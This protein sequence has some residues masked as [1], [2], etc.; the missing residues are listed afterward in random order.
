M[1]EILIWHDNRMSSPINN[2]EWY[3]HR[4]EVIT[5][6][7]DTERVAS[8]QGGGAAQGDGEGGDEAVDLVVVPEADAVNTVESARSS[9]ALAPRRRE[10]EETRVFMCRKWL[11]SRDTQLGTQAR[12]VYSELA[13]HAKLIE[14]YDFAIVMPKTQLD[15]HKNLPFEKLVLFGD[16]IKDGLQISLPKTLERVFSLDHVMFCFKSHVGLYFGVLRGAMFVDRGGAFL[17]ASRG[18]R[19]MVTCYERAAY[20]TVHFVPALVD[21]SFAHKALANLTATCSPGWA[22]YGELKTMLRISSRQHAVEPSA[23]LDDEMLDGNEVSEG[24]GRDA[25]LFAQRHK[26]HGTID[27]RTEQ[28]ARKDSTRTILNTLEIWSNILESEDFDEEESLQRMIPACARLTLVAVAKHGALFLEHLDKLKFVFN[29]ELFPMEN[30]RE[31]ETHADLAIMTSVFAHLDKWRRIEPNTYELADIRISHCFAWNMLYWQCCTNPPEPEAIAFVLEHGGF[32]SHDDHSDSAGTAEFVVTGLEADFALMLHF[33]VLRQMARYDVLALQEEESEAARRKAIEAIENRNLGLQRRWSRKINMC[34]RAAIF[35]ILFLLAVIHM[36][37][38]MLTAALLASGWNYWNDR[39]MFSQFAEDGVLQ[40][41]K[42]ESRRL[43]EKWRQVCSGNFSW[44]KRRCPITQE[45]RRRQEQRHQL[46]GKWTD[47]IFECRRQFM[48][49]MVPQVT[50]IGKSMTRWFS[51]G[52]TQRLASEMRK[53]STACRKRE[54]VL[55][56][57]CRFSPVRAHR[58]SFAYKQFLRGG[59][60]NLVLLALLV[61]CLFDMLGLGWYWDAGSDLS[62][63]LRQM[64]VDDD[65]DDEHNT[66]NEIDKWE[67]WWNFAKGTLAG[68]LTAQQVYAGSDYR[69]DLRF[70]PVLLRQVRTQAGDDGVLP[71]WGPGPSTSMED[72]LPLQAAIYLERHENNTRDG[73]VWSSPPNAHYLS[74]Y[75]RGQRYRKYPA[76]GY[77]VEL[78]KDD[79]VQELARLEDGG[80]FDA[81]TRFVSVEGMVYSKSRDRM[82]YVNLG[83]EVSVAGW[84]R[85]V[86]QIISFKPSEFGVWHYIFMIIFVQTLGNE[87]LCILS[88]GPRRYFTGAGNIINLLMAGCIFSVFICQMVVISQVGKYDRTA[89]N[90]WPAGRG[91]AEAFDINWPLVTMV[92]VQRVCASISILIWFLKFLVHFSTVP[93]CGP[94]VLGIFELLRQPVIL[95]FLFCYI[96]ML[97]GFALC[98]F[99]LSADAVDPSFRQVWNSL[100]SMVRAGL[101]GDFEFTTYESMDTFTG[102]VL[103]V[104]MIIMSQI[105]MTNLFI[106]IISNEYDVARKKGERKW[107][108]TMALY[109][110]QELIDSLPVDSSGNIDMHSSAMLVGHDLRVGH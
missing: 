91:V 80:W 50:Q 98:F 66:F 28:K 87:A 100:S 35:P 27:A 46:I 8:A 71:V 30:Q 84:T 77:M 9:L 33:L 37:L 78:T 56:E 40:P 19:V 53:K 21:D 16:R 81:A 95:F 76:S 62:A 31:M 60:K 12:L 48:M 51:I 58:T 82:A 43:A 75:T 7:K 5:R 55:E 14:T 59:V 11:T 49:A 69:G 110:A 42:E 13:S 44:L 3:L 34:L 93:V 38:N 86:V 74:A 41:T 64:L 85:P 89:D 65:F 54:L 101:A 63:D 109:M 92:E 94:I 90:P 72:K 73:C 108:N 17:P 20:N 104:I 47:F 36:M 83:A 103:F 106:A 23:P 1:A 70:S 79:V 107:R 18:V 45:E 2:P 57:L 4:V 99:F 32:E 6:N 96:W 68:V 22:G 61:Y 15:K 102:P 24:A 52:T 39:R 29:E 10:G 105:I 97:S 25:P 26:E 88:L 67:D